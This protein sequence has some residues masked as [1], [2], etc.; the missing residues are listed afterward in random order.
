MLFIGSFE[1]STIIMA[2]SEMFTKTVHDN[3][4]LRESGRAT[5]AAVISMKN[6]PTRQLL[7]I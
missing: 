7:L 2:F 3:F 1:Y 4:T 6:L 5:V